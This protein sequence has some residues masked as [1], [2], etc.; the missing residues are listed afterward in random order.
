VTTNKGFSIIELCAYLALVGIVLGMALPTFHQILM[1][2]ERRMIMERVHTAIALAKQQ[3]FARNTTLT[4]CG[5]Y[6]RRT[7]HPYKDWSRGFILIASPSDQNQNTPLMPTLIRVFA[8][9]RYG[10]LVFAQ[11]STHLQIKPDG[12][13]ERNGTF[14]YCPLDANRFEADALVINKASH[15]YKLEHRN[16]HGI[17]LRDVGTPQEAPIHC[18]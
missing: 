11:F 5:S 12:H 4:L 1:R 7:C 13:N 2:T 14:I 6:D 8:G 16:I 9:T 3:A 18:R 17:L 15:L 10:T